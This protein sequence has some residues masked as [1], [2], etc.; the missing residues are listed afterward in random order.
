MKL[1]INNINKKYGKQFALKDFSVTLTDGVYGLLGPNGAGKTTLIN[2]I[3][4]ILKPDDGNIR[5]DG[6]DVKHLGTDYYNQVGYLPQYPQFYKNFTCHEF[7]EYMCALKGVEHKLSKERIE[8]L[9][10][11]VN[12]TEASSK[13]VGAF[14][15]GMRQR[16]GIAQALLNN[17]KILILDEPTAGLDPKERI[18]FRNIIS[19]LSKERIVIL[20]THIVS[21]VEYIAK[22]IVIINKGKLVQKGTL[23]YLTG[24]IKDKVWEVEA[25]EELTNRLLEEYSVGNIVPT[26]QGY[27]IKIVSETMPDI[28]AVHKIPTLEDVFLDYFG[29][30]QN[31]E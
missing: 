15:G 22:E 21:D 29:K 31:K 2:I 26:N 3:L 1:E 8:E 11:L 24:Q 19:K 16:L 27:R 12:L 30:E 5:L 4:G 17:P 10:H 25:D 20:A 13:K 23:S 14:S 28:K 9:L 7:L 18:R 6:A